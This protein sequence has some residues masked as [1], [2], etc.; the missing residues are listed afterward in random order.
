MT[1]WEVF[2]DLFIWCIISFS[3]GFLVGAL[4]PNKNR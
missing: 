1:Y 2:K 4:F 3:F